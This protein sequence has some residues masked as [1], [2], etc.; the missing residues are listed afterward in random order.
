MSQVKCLCFIV[1]IFCSLSLFSQDILINEISSSNSVHND[2]DGDTPDWIE[3]YNYGTSDISLHNWGLSDDGDELDKWV[4]PNI[5]ISPK[6]YLLIWASSKDKKEISY[7]R[8]FVKEGDIF[9]YK[10]PTTEL[11]SQ[12]TSLN[13]DDSSWN[14]GASGFGY[15]DG[16][17]ATIVANGTKSVYTRI[18]FNI[19][20]ISNITSLF[21]DIDYDDGFVAYLNGKEIKRANINGV[22]PAFDSGTLTDHEAK[23]YSGGKPDRFIIDD[24]K[25]KLVEGENVLAI[26]VH[27]V[28]DSSSDMTL[29]P[30]LSVI[31]STSESQG[32]NPPSILGLKG[33]NFHTNFKISSK[34]ET[35]YLSDSNGNI[36]DQ[37]LA[38]GLH[39][40]S[41]IGKSKTDKS[42]I[43]YYLDTTPGK[44]NSDTEYEGVISSDVDFSHQGGS[45]SGSVNLELSGNEAGQTI[46]YTVSTI[47]AIN[48]RN[49]FNTAEASEP[50]ESSTAYTSP[51]S[52]TSP[53]GITK[54][55]V[56]R[57]KI[58]KA[59]YIPSLTSSR[60]FLFNA[61]HQIDVVTLTTE[62][63]NLLDNDDG[64]YVLGDSYDSNSPH[65]GANFWEDWERPI[66]FSFYDKSTKDIKTSFNGGVKI[67]GGWSRAREQRS[68]S[69][70]ARGKYGTTEID[71]SFFEKANYDKF[72]ALVL[73]NSGQDFLRSSTKDITLTSLME[74]SGIDY[75][76]HTPVATY[77]NGRYW[78]VYNLRE[79]INEHMLAS[80]HNLDADDITILERNAEII[81]GSNESYKQLI[82]YISITDL[83]NDSNFERVRNEIDIKN[84]IIY[85]VAQIFIANSDWPGNNI[86][87]WTHPQGKWRWILFDTDFGF[88]RP[89]VAED[90]T[91]NTLS[92]AL[93]SNGPHWPNP[94]W[95]TLLFRKLIQ[96]TKFRNQFINR[97]ADELNTRFLTSNVKAHI[98]N[99][100]NKVKPELASHYRRWEGD[101]NAI[102]DNINKMKKFAEERPF[103]AKQHLKQY[104]SLPALMKNITIKNNSISKGY[105]KVNDNLKIKSSQ[106]SGEYFESVPIQLEA[107]A[108]TGF[109][110]S[111]WSGASSSTNP[112]IEIDLTQN[113]ELTPHFKPFVKVPI[114]INE[115][116]YKSGDEQDTDDW[117]ELYNPNSKPIDL[118]DW[119]VKDDDDTH[120]FNIPQDTNIEA[121]GYLIIA[122][123]KE[124]FLSFFLSVTN[125][126]GDIDFGLGSKSD[127]VRLYNDT[128][129]L[130]DEVQ[131]DFDNSW[132]NCADG[133]GSTLELKIPGL[134]NNNPTNWDCINDKGSP[135]KPNDE[136]LTN[137]DYLTS[138]LK[139]YPN[140]VKDFLYVEGNKSKVLITI[141]SVLGTEV[142]SGNIMNRLD[143]SF[144][145]QGLYFVNIKYENQTITKKLIKQ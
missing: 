61:N 145:K 92:F 46:R 39:S 81:E 78:G 126:V 120:I 87:F 77:I 100:Y 14:S 127:A 28:S 131:Y 56:V 138:I 90:Y 3:L 82:S 99:I 47:E 1:I 51:I 54:N 122:K 26:Q 113:K 58:F 118:S 86:K 91:H 112:K 139:V 73:R 25:N 9:K 136:S 13:F 19:A 67:F 140:F 4:F 117:I 110:F 40:D 57:A 98:D 130:E 32:Y 36:I 144:L 49:N 70:F 5:T 2:E 129:V 45:V 23:M 80:K 128:D 62:R 16:D 12:W 106:W 15:A 24:F 60:T 42:K 111:H 11:S 65:F 123:N 38:A 31:F 133:S 37:L 20:N 116:N 108:E 79:K 134:D 76:Y 59:N 22:P 52:I 142:I 43:V 29:I 101:S 124:D 6:Q 64:I 17:D 125:V 71:Y 84:Y 68:L 114:V 55:T 93:S 83:T 105:V 135:G 141:Y 143:I 27:N 66:H 119:V 75:Q 121:K 35:V 132:P 137:K 10:I 41:T 97:Y 72:Q 8:T 95:S 48:V 104:F 74:G 85:Q 96:N 89:W 21:L 94:P 7:T 44:E 50:T 88:T 34:S 53:I 107:I 33:H 18:K 30:F 103:Y 69:I 115:I 63:K 102:I 109:E